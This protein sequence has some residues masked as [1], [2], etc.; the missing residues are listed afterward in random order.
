MLFLTS[1]HKPL[2]PNL[3]TQTEAAFWLIVIV[4]L[5]VLL[6]A[7]TGA[8]PL[9]MPPIVLS[10]LLLP[11]RAVLALPG[12]ELAHQDSVAT[13]NLQANGAYQQLQNAITGLAVQA[14]FHRPIK[15]VISRRP[16]EARAFG[17]WRRHYL[18]LGEAVAT[19]LV[20]DLANETHRAKAQAMLLHEI[21][22]IVHK[23]VQR[24]GYT[25]QL[26][27]SCV[28]IVPWWMFF[29]MGWLSFSLLMGQAFLD[30]DPAGFANADPLLREL[31]AG[32]WN[33]SPATRADI[34]GKVQ[35]ISLGLL[36]N[37][38]VYAFW[39]IAV[40]GSVLWLFYWRQM[41]RV[42]EYYA[43]ALAAT[44]IGGE[45]AVLQ[46]MGRYRTWFRPAVPAPRLAWRAWPAQFRVG[47]RRL[48]TPRSLA[49]VGQP[50]RS[51][52]AGLRQWFTL[53]PTYKQRYQCLQ[54]PRQIL[55]GWPQTAWPAAF[56]TLALDVM[57]ISPLAS[58]YLL[59]YPIHFG[60]L[61]IFALLSVWL[62]PHVVQG[63]PFGWP[64]AKG[65][66]AI[67]GVRWLWLAL[68]LGLLLGVVFLLPG[69]AYEE[70][71]LLVLAMSGFSRLPDAMPVTD[72]A[73][74]ALQIIP[75]YLLL[76]MFQLAVVVGLL[77]AYAAWQR[78]A[79]RQPAAP[80]R[81]VNWRRRHW[82]GLLAFMTAAITLLLTPVT[83]LLSGELATLWQPG[84]VI[85]YLV[86][87]N[88]AAALLLANQHGRRH[89]PNNANHSG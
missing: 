59:G 42:Q 31:F 15:L 2:P 8:S 73:G 12:R 16:D 46:A 76:Q 80:G 7:G 79:A 9:Y 6:A 36:L 70:L 27:R 24:I 41:V 62:L 87:L 63:E 60:T 43:D 35:T 51:I 77:L 38:I 10:L 56:L 4:F 44:G 74:L 52:P 25:R 84:R 32:A 23:D 82:L 66:L 20:E 39:P 21:G 11:L 28:T 34:A 50:A 48:L 3:P 13:Q 86:G 29:L 55:A 19:K 61:A 1:E 67:F 57:L 37:F 88:C 69:I 22:H 40:T 5:G 53:H 89:E 72:P 83:D 71:N 33:I 54:E 30:F 47:I 68:N 78:A 45:L 81:E 58:Y 65:L 49:F 26:L 14:G 75:G 17:S 64:L 18:L 85:G